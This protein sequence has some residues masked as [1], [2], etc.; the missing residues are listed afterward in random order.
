MH[1]SPIRNRLSPAI[2][3]IRFIF[4]ATFLLAHAATDAQVNLRYE[5]NLTLSY[6]EVIQAY[7]YLDTSYETAR[8]IEYGPTDVGKPLHLFVISADREF[9]PV[10]VRASGK[11][12]ILIINGIHPGESAGVDASIRFADELL[13]HVG[14]IQSFLENTVVCIVPVYNIGGALM[15]SAFNR[16]NQN[17]PEETGFRGNARNLD[18]NR[19]FIKLDT[20]NAQSFT[21]IF[22]SWQPDIFLDTHTT[23]GSDHQYTITLNATN[24]QKIHQR[25]GRFMTDVYIPGLYDLMAE[26]PYEMI[27][28]VNYVI[29]SPENGI[30]G[31]DDLPRYSTGYASLF[32]TL[33]FMTENHAYKEFPDRVKS[34]YHFMISLLKMTHDNAGTIGEI[35]EA[36][37]KETGEQ[38]A[39]HLSWELDTTRFDMLTFKGYRQKTRTGVFTGAEQNYYDR[40]DPYTKEIPY[41]N[42]YQ[43]VHSVE[44]P[45]AYII[46]QVWSEVIERLTLNGIS[47]DRLQADTMISVTAYYIADIKIGS[48]LYNGHYRHSDIQL[49]AEIQ[50]IQFYKG[51]YVVPVTQSANRY[52][53]ETL[54]PDAPDSFLHW[55]FFDPVLERR[56]YFSP[57]YFEEAALDLLNQDPELKKAYEERMAGDPEFSENS[58]ARLQFIYM[59][60]PYA[61]KSYRRYPVFRLEK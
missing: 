38:S 35:R 37:R 59:N 19:D 31:Y 34:V 22:Q 14:G 23:N 1:Y 20:K 15:R 50:A 40:D 8:L 7:R 33:G 46:P 28:Y 55:N 39:F 52:I 6:D 9:D 51:D 41:Y 45:A 58:Y 25:L 32:N 12:I 21:E 11:R 53:I 44:K 27:P 13:Q 10:A 49:S 16:T 4:V 47:M 60:S 54:E 61:E 26:T 36:A 29:S 2:K 57:S 30:T 42:Y 56:E 5:E 18:L 24:Q 3:T 17:G 48:R 43:P